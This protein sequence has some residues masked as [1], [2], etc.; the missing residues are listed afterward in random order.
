MVIGDAR[1]KHCPNNVL[2]VTLVDIVSY[3][4]YNVCIE[5]T[6]KGIFIKK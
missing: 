2:Y 6:T 3:I 5:S 1:Y 4:G